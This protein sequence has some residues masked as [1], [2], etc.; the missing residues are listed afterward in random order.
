[1]FLTAAR[2]APE[3]SIAVSTVASKGPVI[4]HVRAAWTGEIRVPLGSVVVFEALTPTGPMPDIVS[5]GPVTAHVRAGWPEIRAPPGSIVVFEDIAA[6]GAASAS[7]ASASAASASA[8]SASAA[9]ASAAAAPRYGESGDFRLAESSRELPR[10]DRA[11]RKRVARQRQ[12]ARRRERRE[13]QRAAD[14]AAVSDGQ[15]DECLTQD[16][17]SRKECQCEE[18]YAEAALLEAALDKRRKRL[19]AHLAAKYDVQLEYPEA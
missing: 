18:F 5:E 15:R 17:D 19:L 1:M 12:R 3:G 9:S 2:D 4:V 8:A 11:D 10:T 14:R 7:A 6:P 13:D 16:P